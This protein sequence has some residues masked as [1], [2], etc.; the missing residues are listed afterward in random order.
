MTL[1]CADVFMNAVLCFC[2]FY[3]KK[4]SF[5]KPDGVSITLNE[6]DVFD[7]N[8]ETFIYSSLWI[9]K[10]FNN[11][12]TLSY[13][14]FLQLLLILSGDIELNPGPNTNYSDLINFTK[15]KGFVVLHQNIRGLQ[16]G[17]DLIADVL[18]HNKKIDIF[19]LSETFLRN[20][21]IFDTEIRGYD[22][23]Y[24]CRSEGKGGGVGAYIKHGVPYKRR[25]DLEVDKVE[26]MWLE[27]S[28]KN[29]KPF[30]IGILYRPPDSSNYS[31]TNFPT[32]LK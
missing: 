9:H 26:I 16:A 32:S 25:N 24:K 8:L 17:K 7:D 28:F 22:F 10:R 12:A 5:L 21:V 13:K 30:L 20:N 31:N 18:F 2:I 14:G 23:E 15:H 3:I 1:K 27:I 29:T 4:E 19:S 11:K 6:I